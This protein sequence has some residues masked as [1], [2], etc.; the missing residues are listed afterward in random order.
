MALIG[1][2]GFCGQMTA[3]E[4][5]IQAAADKYATANCSCEEGKVYRDKEVCLDRIADLCQAPRTET[6]VNPLSKDETSFIR[7]VADRVATSAV[8]GA[9]IN[10]RG[11]V[12]R[13]R[14]GNDH[15]PVKFSR[16]WKLELTN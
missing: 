3:T 14:P 2:C 9:D 15:V 13:L 12:I 11:T 8:E 16:I 5:T 4:M 7:N 1:T 6:G 10:I